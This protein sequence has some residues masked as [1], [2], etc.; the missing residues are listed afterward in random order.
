MTTQDYMDRI[1]EVA[2]AMRSLIPDTPPGLHEEMERIIATC[3]SITYAPTPTD[4]EGYDMSFQNQVRS[5][6]DQIQQSSKGGQTE[7]LVTAGGESL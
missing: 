4:N 5:L 2:K 3:D 7:S 1:E 6:L